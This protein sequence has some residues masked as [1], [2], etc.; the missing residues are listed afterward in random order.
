MFTIASVIEAQYREKPVI[1]EEREQNAHCARF[2]DTAVQEALWTTPTTKNPA[3]GA[4]FGN[5]A[6]T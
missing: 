2:W 5:K 6:Y 3:T 4:G 1:R